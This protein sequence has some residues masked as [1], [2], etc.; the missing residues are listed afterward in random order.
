MSMQRNEDNYP[1]SLKPLGVA[2]MIANQLV[3]LPV[4]IAMG[5]LA[6]LTAPVAITIGSLATLT[7]ATDKYLD[8]SLNPKFKDLLANFT[9]NIPDLSTA[10]YALNV[11]NDCSND[12]QQT[13]RNFKKNSLEEISSTTIQTI[14]VAVMIAGNIVIVPAAVTMG[15]G[16]AVL[17]TVTD[18]CLDSSLN[19]LLK[20]WLLDLTV[21]TTSASFALNYASKVFNDWSDSL[22]QAIQNF[23][24]KQSEEISSINK[25]S[26]STNEHI[27]I[28]DLKQNLTK[29]AEKTIQKKH[30]VTLFKSK[31][32][33][34]QKP[35]EQTKLLNSVSTRH[36]GTFK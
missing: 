12:L 10:N 26:I 5:S 8:S 11:F 17:T 25:D 32:L 13:I 2:V 1:D 27:T 29:H 18:E 35:N 31:I 15:G 3:I 24:N 6:V 30:G 33:P 22:Q 36:Y 9:N 19:L 21:T 16:L 20:N 28:N 14:G 34:T 7:L 23:R 4:A